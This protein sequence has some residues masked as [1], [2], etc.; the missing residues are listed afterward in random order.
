MLD[1]DIKREIAEHLGQYPSAQAASVEALQAVQRRFGWVSDEHLRE[2][3][4]LL[5]MDPAEL[6][7]VASFYNLIFRRPVGRNVI[8]VCDSVS[9]WILGC[10]RIFAALQERLGIAPGQ[11]TEDGAFTLLPMCCLGDCDHAPVLMI[12]E[13]THRDVDPQALGPLLARYRSP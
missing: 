4:A 1:E 12:G 8:L 13:D 2:V 6:D 11:T 7:A 9:C 10:D 3:A 5:H